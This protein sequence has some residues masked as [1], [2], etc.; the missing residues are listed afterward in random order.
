MKLF[1]IRGLPGSGKSTFAKM[2]SEATETAHYEADMFFIEDGEYKFD[3]K[4][5]HAAHNWCQENV[6]REI[7]GGG[8]VIVSNTFVKLWEMDAY[9]KL[10]EQ[11][12]AQITEIIVNG[13]HGSIHGVPEETIARMRR[14]FEY[15]RVA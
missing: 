11:Y 9:K 8:D 12:G 15:G 7:R 3:A 4:K 1:I 5:L 10:A 14:D 2:L 6:E 13:N